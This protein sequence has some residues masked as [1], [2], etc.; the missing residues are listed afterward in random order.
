MNE[1][2][3]TESVEPYVSKTRTRLAFM[4]TRRWRRL[5]RI[6]DGRTRMCGRRL[7]SIFRRSRGNRPYCNQVY[8][9]TCA[10]I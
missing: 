6:A 8:V 5:I 1:D 7:E 10:K 2:W 9:S 4:R 3:C